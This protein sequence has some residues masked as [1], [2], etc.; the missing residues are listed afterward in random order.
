MGNRFSKKSPPETFNNNIGDDVEYQNAPMQYKNSLPP[1]LYNQISPQSLDFPRHQSTTEVLK[2]DEPLTLRGSAPSPTSATSS[3]E[4]LEVSLKFCRNFFSPSSQYE[5]WPCTLVFQAPEGVETQ[6]S[7]V[8]IICVIDVSGSM[9]GEKLDLV[10]KTLDFMLTQLTDIDR[11]S[12][13]A[14]SD[15]AEKV[16]PLTVMNERGK[17]RAGQAIARLQVIGGTN[18]VSGLDLGIKVATT[19]NVENYSTAII[20]LTDGCDD[21]GSTASARAK[22][23]IETHSSANI[24]YTIHCFGYGA[25]HDATTLGA[26]AELKNGGFYYVEKFESIAE[27]F[28][29][30]LGELLSAMVNEVEVTLSTQACEI[31]FALTK[32]Y[33]STGDIQFGMPNIM[34]G[35]TKEAVFVLGFQPSDVIPSQEFEITPIRARVSYTLIKTSEKKVLERELRIRVKEAGEQ[36]EID[37]SVLVNFYRVKAA[38]ILREA[39]VLGDSGRLVEARDLLEKAAGEFKA[40][41]VANDGLIKI[42]V[43]DF[44]EG[45]LRFRDRQTYEHGGRA[46]MSSKAVGHAKKRGQNVDVYQNSCQKRMQISSANYFA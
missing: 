23:C 15:S 44:E 37:E 16:I 10:K 38:D 24:S 21:S 34:Y 45:K 4:D 36:V 11:I 31:A 27:A 19:R 2:D 32:V 39:G 26:I 46:E 40:S 29:N 7:G 6:R 9:N 42:L 5:E 17:A 43:N 30:C 22:S 14:F 3:P 12:I 41:L 20:L 1:S 25:D 28:A 35:D 18:I 13:V 33:S 8:D